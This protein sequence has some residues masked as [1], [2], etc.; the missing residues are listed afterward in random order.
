MNNKPVSGYEW[1]GEYSDFPVE[2]WAYEASNND[3]RLG[4]WDWVKVKIAEKEEEEEN[5]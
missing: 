4:Y 2:D 5:G 1:W 3:T